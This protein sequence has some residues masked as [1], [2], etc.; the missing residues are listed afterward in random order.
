MYA[1]R[2][3]ADRLPWKTLEEACVQECLPDRDDYVHFYVFYV[4]LENISFNLRLLACSPTKCLQ[5][6]RVIKL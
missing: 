1:R 6:D 3:A 4:V 2:D 5:F